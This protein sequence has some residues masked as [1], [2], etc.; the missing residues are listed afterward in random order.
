MGL[1]CA[2]DILRLCNRG[3]GPFVKIDEALKG[4]L[5]GTSE[6][7]ESIVEAEV[8][9]TAGDVDTSVVSGGSGTSTSGDVDLC[10]GV[11]GASVTIGISVDFLDFA[12]DVRCAL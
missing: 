7:R 12:L 8:A 2:N 9:D 3:I 11:D 10:V 5:Y 4:N 1:D 6:G